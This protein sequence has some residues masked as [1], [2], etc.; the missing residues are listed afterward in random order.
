MVY[1]VVYT[2]FLLKYYVVDLKYQGESQAEKVG[3]RHHR[4]FVPRIS[5]VLL[6]SYVA[7]GQH[8]ELNNLES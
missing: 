8:E 5:F 7:T 3:R 6:H 1:K 4:A 2:R